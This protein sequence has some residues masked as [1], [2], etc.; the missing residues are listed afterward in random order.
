MELALVMTS[1]L[2]LGA[3]VFAVALL[4][5]R[6]G[7]HASLAAERARADAA[8]SQA[9][10]TRAQTTDLTARLDAARTEAADAR[11]RAAAL[12]ERLAAQADAFDQARDAMLDTFNA[13]ASKA[14]GDSS[15]SFLSLAEQRFQTLLTKGNA[16]LDQRKAEVDRLVA[17]ITQT[18]DKTKD[19]IDRI[20][21][22]RVNSFAQLAEQVRAAADTTTSLREETTQL[23]QAL[24]EPTVRGR[25]GETQ[26]RRVAELAGMTAYCDFDLQDQTQGQDQALR[27]D[28]V[29]RLPGDRTIVVDA[30]ANILAFLDALK[31]RDPALQ[32]QH[33]DR[34]AAH[35]A[36][37]ATKLARKR[38]WSQYEGSPEFVVMF[39]PGDHFLDAAL[40]RRPELLDDAARQNVILA[41]PSS[42]IAMLRAVAAVH[43]QSRLAREAQELRA[44]GAELHKR[45]ADA[46]EHAKS[47]GTHL[48]RAVDAYNKFLGSYQSRLEPHLRKFEDAGVK[49]P[50]DLPA[51]ESIDARPRLFDASSSAPPAG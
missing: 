34:F 8:V 45:A 11:T 7:L 10:Q 27:P 43:A 41:T 26:L 3:A 16:D 44:L 12:T 14:L 20:E 23:T 32:A 13:A 2:A 30:K 33:L 24:R 9:E 39:I 35:V 22:E 21:K 51:P 5:Q 19:L 49:G 37:Q 18:L 40:K 31:E 25:Y 50:K 29:V 36:D 6:A 48:D 4:L 46:I 38:Y 1:L 17:P 42:L 15:K 28:M 47:L